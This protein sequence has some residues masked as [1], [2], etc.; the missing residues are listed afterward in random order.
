ML[1]CHFLISLRKSRTI[2]SGIVQ[3]R[4]LNIQ[5][6]T[7]KIELDQPPSHLSDVLWPIICITKNRFYPL[8]RIFFQKDKSKGKNILIYEIIEETKSLT[9]IMVS[10]IYLLI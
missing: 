9:K 10:I 3:T 2:Q 8:N 4:R 1:L 5:Q 7:L 6:L